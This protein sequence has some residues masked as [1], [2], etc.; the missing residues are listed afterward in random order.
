MGYKAITCPKCG[1]SRLHVE[2]DL[3]VCDVCE[4]TFTKEEESSLEEKLD[5]YK[6]MNQEIDLGHLRYLIR[7]ELK[8][9]IIELSISL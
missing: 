3:F 1:E 8:K 7:N 9:E 2:G 4:S 6:Q 5:Q